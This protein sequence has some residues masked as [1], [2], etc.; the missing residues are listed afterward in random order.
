M[1][2]FSVVFLHQT[3]LSIMLLNGCVLLELDWT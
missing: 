3:Y 2:V 1:T